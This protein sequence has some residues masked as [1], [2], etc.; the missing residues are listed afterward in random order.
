MTGPVASETG[1]DASASPGTS[2]MRDS[3][4]AIG[5]LLAAGLVFRLIIAYLLP[6]SGF[7]VDLGAFEYWAHNLAAQRMYAEAG[8]LAENSGPP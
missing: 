7:K 8:P 3:A 6:G 5:A 1:R 2:G 4:R